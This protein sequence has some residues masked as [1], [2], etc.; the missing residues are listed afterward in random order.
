MGYDTLIFQL[1]QLIKNT[2]DEETKQAL[3]LIVWDI[4][5]NGIQ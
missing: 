5:K 4:T 3:T 2:T 1:N